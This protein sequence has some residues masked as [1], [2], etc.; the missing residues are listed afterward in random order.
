MIRRLGLAVVALGALGASMAAAEDKPASVALPAAASGTSTSPPEATPSPAPAEIVLAPQAEALRKRLAALPDGNDDEER[1]ERAALIAFYEARQFAPHWYSAPGGITSKGAAAKAEIER[2]ADWGLDPRAYALPSISMPGAGAAL[3]PDVLAEAE[4]K[5]SV[6]VLLYGRH[7]RG[8]RIIHPAKQLS[9]YLDRRP[10][11]L[12]PQ[13]ILDGIAG[14][15]EPDAYLRGLHPQHPQFERL[16]QKYLAASSRTHGRGKGS[17]GE[18]AAAKRLL[19]NMEQ[20]RWMPAEMGPFYV[21]NNIPEFMQRVVKDGEV[22]QT[23]RIVAGETGKQTPIF[24]RPMRRITLKPTWIVPDSIK[25][26]ELW[27]S[28]LRGGGLMREWALEIQSKEGARVDWRKIDW[29]KT[30]ILDYDVV[31]PNGPKSVM[32][33]VKFSFPN[34]HTVFMHDTLPRDKYM[35]NV[36]RRTYSHGCMRV[37]QPIKLVEAILREDQGWTAERVA[38]ALNSGPL[39]NEITLERRVPVHVSYFTAWVTDDGQLKMF[40]DVYGHEQRI[41]LALEGKWERIKT[42]HDHLAPVA[43]DLNSAQ[44]VASEDGSLDG[45]PARN[46]RSGNSGNGDLFRSVFGIF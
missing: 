34:P 19:A 28:L 37:D 30:N 16:R 26:R 24:S 15:G 21:W 11:L 44:R 46:G 8:G 33:K 10:Q 22:V 45:V 38:E 40:P 23:H 2:A 17:A 12:K 14:A 27:P 43:V 9:S 41:T 5:F 39:N 4:T 31:Q 25:A 35:F 20:W 32:G 18:S 29:R 6:A 1:N 42:G 3:A 36:A 7:A 13:V